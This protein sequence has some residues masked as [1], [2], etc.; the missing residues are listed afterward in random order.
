MYA[1]YIDLVCYVVDH[2]IMYINLIRFPTS[3]YEQ[4]INVSQNNLVKEIA[5][6]WY[7]VAT[8]L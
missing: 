1:V 3:S 6:N 7:I 8:G 2:F 5:F 4:I